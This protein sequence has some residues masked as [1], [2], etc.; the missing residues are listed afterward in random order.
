MSS[1]IL[2][3]YLSFIAARVVPVLGWV[4]L[5]FGLS[6]W[7]EW[8][9]QEER[10][11]AASSLAQAA[12]LQMLRYQVNPHFLFNAMNS[13]RALID[14]NEHKAREI[15][16]ELSAFLRYSLISKDC[17]EVPLKEEVEAI[18][19]YFAIQMKRYE[20]KLEVRYDIDP[21]AGEYP[22]LSFLI[23]PFIENA[24]KYGMR[25]SPL[26]LIIDLAARIQD[27]SLVVTVRNTGRWEEPRQEE[28]PGRLGTGA[29]LANVRR[30]LENAY[31]DNHRID[32][33]E[34][35]GSVVVQ[36]TIRGR[37]GGDHK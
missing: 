5:Y 21:Q 32:I 4:W 2:G 20:D 30:R 18:R 26:P 27:R 12:Q 29:G 15:I 16:T 14:E 22:V 7:R 11:S 36:L 31:P 10:A 33:H 17:A 3:G 34:K 6:I 25:T 1:S 9:Q 23:H 8:R 37:G 19:Y 24:V 35:D 28:G 13:I